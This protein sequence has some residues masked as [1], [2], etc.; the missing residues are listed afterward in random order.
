MSKV[1]MVCHCG[2]KS[3]C[4]LAWRLL[5]GGGMEKRTQEGM[6][7]GALIDLALRLV[8]LSHVFIGVACGLFYVWGFVHLLKREDW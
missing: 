6:A 7:M 4:G 5:F 2:E 8:P 3:D 1:T